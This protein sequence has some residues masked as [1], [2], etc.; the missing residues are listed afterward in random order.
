[1]PRPG[2]LLQRPSFGQWSDRFLSTRQAGRRWGG[3]DGRLASTDRRQYLRGQCL[4]RWPPL[5]VPMP[6]PVP[7]PV[8]APVPAVVVGGTDMQLVVVGAAVVVGAPVGAVV[9]GAAVV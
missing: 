2:K 4:G 5:P 1:M 7:V 8:P 9:V 6:V 3:C